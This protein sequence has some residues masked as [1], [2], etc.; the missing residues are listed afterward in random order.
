MWM[1]G[2]LSRTMATS[3]V[4]EVEA[5]VVQSAKM[6]LRCTAVG[7]LDAQ[8]R[9]RRI[10]TPGMPL[11]A[12]TVRRASG[13]LLWYEV[14]IARPHPP[15]RRPSRKILSVVPYDFERLPQE[16]RFA[17]EEV[18]RHTSPPPTP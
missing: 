18:L 9:L 8:G 5:R 6:A 15:S 10:G 2:I 13:V 7:M 14:A 17:L 12:A 16:G 11:L 1:R 4:G 3:W